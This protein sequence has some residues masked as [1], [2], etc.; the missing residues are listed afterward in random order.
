MKIRAA[1]VALIAFAAQLSN[2]AAA[3]QPARAFKLDDIYE[4]QHV[5]QAAIAPQ[6]DRVAVVVERWGKESRWTRHGVLWLVSTKDGKVQ[7][8]V[9]DASELSQTK[10][11]WS[12]DG[13]QLMYSA[14]TD[15]GSQLRVLRL[16][17]MSVTTVAA[18]AEKET[19]A[20]SV[21]SPQGAQVAVMCDLT[22]ETPKEV[23]KII[24]A[25]ESDLYADRSMPP[26]S[27]R[28][29]VVV[30]IAAG[31]SR[32]VAKS[33]S[34]LGSDG[35][36]IW[37][38]P[39]DLWIVGTPDGD[40][41]GWDFLAG[42]IMHRVDVG[43][44]KK[45]SLPAVSQ[46][47][48][49]PVASPDGREFMF[50]SGGTVGGGGR[51][52]PET[53]RLVPLRMQ[54]VADDGRQLSES[55]P[56]EMYLGRTS[57][58]VWSRATKN[59]AGGVVY[60]TALERGSGRVKAYY[61]ND[62]RWRDVTEPDVN[63]DSISVTADG[64]RMALVQGD[65]NT[66]ADVY[67]LDLTQP[68]AQPVRLTHFGDSV[69]Q[70]HAVAPIERLKWRSADD[71]FDV[72][73][74]LVKPMDYQRGRRYPLIVDVHGGPGVAF[75]N[76]FS[77][78][79]YD[80]SHM[81]PAELYASKGYMVLMVNP[82]GDPGY[83]RAYQEAL[84]EG[85]EYPTR[86]DILSGVDHVIELGYADPERLGIAGASY[87]GWVTTFAVS[88]TDRFKAAS[89]NDPVVDTATSSAVAYRGDRAS[90]YWLH[91]GFAGGLLDDVPFIG[92]DPKPV[93][94]PILLRFGLKEQAPMPSQFFVSG[95]RYF[96][97]LHTHCRPVEMIMHPEEG[98]GI[99]NT[100]TLRDYIERNTRW[101]DYWLKGEGELP[102][103]RHEC[104]Q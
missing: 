25:T 70:L 101:F 1:T 47:E 51:K 71:R 16:K 17:D 9:S 33:V 31:S 42:R 6:G 20:T 10:P 58:R 72:D 81:V 54:R 60:V 52:I 21:W 92:V 34:Y 2:T 3:S 45:L 29:V 36:L 32:E 23:P 18:C 57:Q 49:M 86:Y 30:D 53:W 95:L 82:R 79:R 59:E 12:P 80:G 93:N 22:L 65:A 41:T 13:K 94:T 87:G 50:A 56:L 84:L 37:R 98:H 83:G 76:R 63:V 55:D 11:A 97:Y 88:Q 19:I 66:P 73:G 35:S 90:N 100:D 40:F 5:V 4:A 46:A 77:D 38:Q 102:F 103:T 48:S 43:G 28:R 78:L 67:L 62:K 99:V 89:A 96:T 7:R 75:R 44:G 15:K 74:W 85:W 8:A 26:R 24:V 104:K 64:R 27:E 69:R 14:L 91:A 68:S 61:P 39:E